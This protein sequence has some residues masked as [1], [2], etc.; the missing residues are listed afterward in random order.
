MKDGGAG[1]IR[2]SDAPAGDLSSAQL[3][4]RRGEAPPELASGG[5]EGVHGLR[6][7]VDRRSQL[8]REHG[9]VDRLAGTNSSD[10]GSDHDLVLSIDDDR[11]VA[12]VGLDDVAL[13]RSRQVDGLLE[14]VDAPLLRLVEAQADGRRL[15]IGVNDGEDPAI[16]TVTV[17]FPYFLSIWRLN[18]LCSTLSNAIE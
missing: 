17:A 11:D 3:Q 9:L 8:D 2:E 18:Q 14:R 15:G 5:R 10:E 12:E 4:R 16:A 6:K 7:R 13:R 1:P